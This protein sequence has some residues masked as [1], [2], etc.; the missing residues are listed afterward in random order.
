MI[1]APPT[2]A[3]AAG[4]GLLLPRGVAAHHGCRRR[5]GRHRPWWP[6]ENVG[7]LGFYHRLAMVTPL[8][9]AAHGTRSSAGRATVAALVER[10]RRLRPSLEVDLCYL[11]VQHPR[12][13]ERL[14]E[15]SGPAVV[16]PMLLSAGYHVVD[17]IPSA[18]ATRA[19]VARHL[20]PDGSITRVL[21]DRLHSAGGDRA[22][23]VALAASPSTRASAGRDLSAAAAHLAAALGRPVRPFTVDG[24]LRAG[25]GTLTGRVAVATYLLSEGFFF[26]T[27]RDAASRAGVGAVSQPLGAHPA[28]ASLVLRRYDEAIRLN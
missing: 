27:L 28:I 23:V 4:G 2:T 5:I 10:V 26:D 6:A 19:R 22:D 9:A 17:D 1:Q 25:L 8:L 12:L 24:S 7:V 20:G 15:M 13:A 21:A 14:D 16:V 3:G 11:D 18:A